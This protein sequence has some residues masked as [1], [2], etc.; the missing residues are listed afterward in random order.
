MNRKSLFDSREHRGGQI[1]TDD[2]LFPKQA[3]Y[4]AVLHPALRRFL[5]RVMSAVSQNNQLPSFQA[6]NNFR[7]LADFQNRTKESETLF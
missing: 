2:L 1:R 6:M 3:H 5:G 7:Q 4:Q